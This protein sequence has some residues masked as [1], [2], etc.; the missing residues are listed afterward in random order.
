MVKGGG[1]E[2]RAGRARATR[3]RGNVGSNGGRDGPTDGMRRTEGPPRGRGGKEPRDNSGRG[4]P[5]ERENSVYV[6]RSSTLRSRPPPLDLDI[7]CPSEQDNIS[8]SRALRVQ[9]RRSLSESG[10]NWA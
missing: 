2:R 8:L 4:L 10:D 6:R 3:R 1:E 9:E 7:D 5:R